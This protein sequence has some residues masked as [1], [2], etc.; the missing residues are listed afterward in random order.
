M[1][2]RICSYCKADLGPAP[3]GCSGDTHG[4]CPTCL[5]ALLAEIDSQ[6]PEYRQD[7][8][9][10]GTGIA[11]QNRGR[12]TFYRFDSISDA[13]RLRLWRL[14]KNFRPETKPKRRKRGNG[15][16]RGKRQVS[17]AAVLARLTGEAMAELVTRVNN[18]VAE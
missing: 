17:A 5:D 6:P 11:V 1:S 13:S 3:A 7:I 2:R 12:V 18:E 4:I 9:Y 15:G 14:A 10:R 16:R 8:C